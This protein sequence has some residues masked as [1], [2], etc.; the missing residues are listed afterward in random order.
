MCRN[1]V[2]NTQK[3][4][5]DRKKQ[6]KS[7]LDR[8][9]SSVEDKR[10]SDLNVA[11]LRR[12]RKS[13]CESRWKKKK[14]SLGERQKRQKRRNGFAKKRRRRSCTERQKK[15]SS[16]CRKKPKNCNA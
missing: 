15:K 10:R 16:D 1:V 9:P 2:G 5:K 13:V 6:R 3:R 14:S 11:A 12:L 7:A 4:R 8:K